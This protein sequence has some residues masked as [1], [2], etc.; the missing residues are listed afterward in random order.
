MIKYYDV[1]SKSKI[2]ALIKGYNTVTNWQKMEG[3]NP[4][5]DLININAFTKFGEIISDCSQNIE[6]K[7]NIDVNLGT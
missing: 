4:N 5:L 2:L 6:W 1:L 7:G 3:R